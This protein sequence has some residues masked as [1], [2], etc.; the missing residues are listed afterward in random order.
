MKETIKR[1]VKLIGKR[2]I[3]FDRYPGD[4]KTQ[5]PPEE[6]FYYERGTKKLVIPSTNILSLLGAQNTDS[7]AKLEVGR[8]Y[9]AIAKACYGFVS[10]DPIDIPLSE[11]G[12]QMTFKGWGDKMYVDDWH[13]PRVKGGIPQPT[14]RPVIEVPW[15]LEFELTLF[16]NGEGL[17]EHLLKRLFVRGGEA[18]GLGSFRGAFGKYAVESWK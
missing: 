3:M 1:N 18:I 2:P 15:E 14:K 10:I 6:K 9:K 4:N 5:L 11:G 7:A 12:K 8:G 13:V 16:S 17:D